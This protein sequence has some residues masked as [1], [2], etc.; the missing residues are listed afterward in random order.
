MRKKKLPYIVRYIRYS[1]NCFLN[2][3]FPTG[4][5]SD[6]FTKEFLRKKDK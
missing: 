6:S 2:L 3:L 1:Y 4:V 5:E